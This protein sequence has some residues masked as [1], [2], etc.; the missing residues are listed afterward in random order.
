MKRQILCIL[1]AAM[2]CVGI[3]WATDRRDISDLEAAKIVQDAQA[4]VVGATEGTQLVMWLP[5]EFWEVCFSGPGTGETERDQFLTATEP[6]V[7]LVVMR[8]G[9]MD[10]DTIIPEFA[11][12]A[13]IVNSTKVTF[14]E[15]EPNAEGE[16][17]EYVLNMV[18]LEDTSEDTQMLVK[19]F[20]PQLAA[21]LGA[22]GSNMQILLFENTDGLGTRP[23]VKAAGAGTLRVDMGAIDDKDIPPTTLELVAP[24]NSLYVPRQ[25]IDCD[26]A[27]H[28]SWNFCPWCGETLEAVVV[29]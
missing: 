11:D 26:Q 28:I 17:D 3:A 27:M 2:V 24:L 8:S 22:M 18:A 15:A 7:M 20:R 12:R 19:L 21:M 25:C 4:Q 29:E 9:I 14:V 16:Y 1:L 5:Q 13:E 6:Y 10:E 23:L